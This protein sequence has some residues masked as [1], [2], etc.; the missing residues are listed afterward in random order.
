VGR[1]RG[2]VFYRS[3]GSA[4]RPGVH[5][6][7]VRTMVREAD[8]VAYQ[9]EPSQRG[10]GTAC[11][12]YGVIQG[13]LGRPLRA[14]VVDGRDC[15]ALE[16]SGS[17]RC[18]W[19]STATDAGRGPPAY[20]TDVTATPAGEAGG[21]G[22]GRFKRSSDL[23]WDE[24]QCDGPALC[25]RWSLALDAVILWKNREGRVPRRRRLLTTVHVSVRGG[26]AM[27]TRFRF[28]RS[29]SR[30]HC[31]RRRG[32]RRRAGRQRHRPTRSE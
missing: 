14:A 15:K 28:R 26:R 8:R 1:S 10:R 31:S 22:C 24:A 32:R 17:H 7:Q 3:G 16:T 23:S 27:N 9:P 12:S 30:L 2:R 21:P 20:G 13:T 18:H 6:S 25:P 11:S 29:A 5:L 4:G 19:S